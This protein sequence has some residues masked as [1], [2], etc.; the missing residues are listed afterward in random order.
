MKTSKHTQSERFSDAFP[1]NFLCRNG[2]PPPLHHCIKFQASN[3]NK[4]NVA[5]AVA[6]VNSA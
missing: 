5:K 6:M 1:V 3:H 4:L 2:V